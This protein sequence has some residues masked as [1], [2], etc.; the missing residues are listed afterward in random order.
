[1]ETT[2]LLRGSE[3]SS[4]LARLLI[5]AEA[6][7][8]TRDLVSVRVQETGHGF[9]HRLLPFAPAVPVD[10]LLQPVVE[11]E[12]QGGFDGLRQ[13]AVG[14]ACQIGLVLQGRK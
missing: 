5:P 12:A 10:A 8:V 2:T 13:Q 4:E 9:T 6:K 1:M 11:V 7:V 14:A 3:K